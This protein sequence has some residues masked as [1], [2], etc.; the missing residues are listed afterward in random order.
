M[1]ELAKWR[2]LL[3]CFWSIHWSNLQ[4]TLL[5][6]WT[7]GKGCPSVKLD[8]RIFLD[9]DRSNAYAMQRMSASH[10][11]R[12]AREAFFY[13][14]SFFST[15]VRLT[16]D[17]IPLLRLRPPDEFENLLHPVFQ[18]DE[19]GPCL[20]SIAACQEMVY[21]DFEVNLVQDDFQQFYFSKWFY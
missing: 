18:E 9:C 14:S 7:K 15:C 5:F 21:Y 17:A 19:L 12:D 16:P 2:L 3:I 20:F 8:R 11:V 1:D 10:H 6:C 4:T 13:C